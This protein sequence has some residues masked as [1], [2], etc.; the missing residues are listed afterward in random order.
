MNSRMKLS[1]P[2]AIKSAA[3]L[4][5]WWLRSLA[6]TLR[7]RYL[8]DADEL[9]PLAHRPPRLYAFWHEAL[10]LPTWAYSGPAMAALISQHRDG[11]LIAQVLRMLR[12]GAIRGSTTRGG[13][14]ALR[15]MLR[16]GRSI[17]LGITPDGPRGP[18]RIVQAGAIYAASH[19][20]LPIV[21]IGVGY[22]RCWRARS[23]DRFAVPL[24]FTTASL[25]LARPV[26]VPPHLDRHQVEPYRA[27]LQHALEEAQA[28][29]EAA[30]T[31]YDR[32]L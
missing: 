5:S 24:P 31:R 17:H 30:A 12:G 11:E 7:I 4:A 9:E 19:A 1:A 10:L 20:Q 32:E 18:R 6:A 23:W 26:H 2:L 13:A 27:Q 21:P 22:A 16:Q 29:A 8:A 15:R 28:R 25:L 3:L 14:T